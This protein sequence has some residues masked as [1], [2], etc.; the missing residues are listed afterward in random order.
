MAFQFLNLAPRRDPIQEGI[1][2]GLKGLTTGLV[3][4]PQDTL[5]LLSMI[6]KRNQS[7]K[8]SEKEEKAQLALESLVDRAPLSESQKMMFKNADKEGRRL[9]IQAWSQEP[10]FIEQL[11]EGKKHPLSPGGTSSLGQLSAEDIPLIEKKLIEQ[12]VDPQSAQQFIQ[13]AQQTN[14]EEPTN[15]LR[16]LLSSGTELATNL[17]LAT[18]ARSYPVAALGTGIEAGLGGINYISE[19]LG[20]DKRV[21]SYE[22]LQNMDF[23]PSAEQ[24]EK[25]YAHYP[26]EIQKYLKEKGSINP[27]KAIPTFG[28]VTEGLKEIG[29]S[30]GLP[31]KPKNSTERAMNHVAAIAGNITKLAQGGSPIETVKS[32]GKSLAAAFGAHTAGKLLGKATGNEKLAPIGEIGSLLLYSAFPGTLSGLSDKLYNKVNKVAGEA[33]KSGKKISNTSYRDKFVDLE[34]NLSEL[35]PLT[36]KKGTIPAGDAYELAT[37]AYNRSRNKLFPTAV[38]EVSPQEISN[39]LSLLRD[40]YKKIPKAGKPYI[41][42]L[43]ELERDMLG[44]GLDK[45]SP[46]TAQDLNNATSLFRSNAQFFNAYKDIKGMASRFGLPGAVAWYTVGLKPYFAGLAGYSGIKYAKA[47]VENPH[48]Q[49]LMTQL[50]KESAIGNT[51]AAGKIITRL[52]KESN[53]ILEKIPEKDRKAILD[54]AKQQGMIK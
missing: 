52:D 12:G 18:L 3:Q 40:T 53:K 50:A 28:Q 23:G 39:D 45:F 38:S 24:K 1:T 26:E 34:G 31:L 16:A 2:S 43:I 25:M 10:G 30:L 19:L 8:K 22:Q 15:P 46:G 4:S 6:E 51:T 37:N 44:K 14:A 29:S 32:L 36:N 54:Y 13:N 9:M 5:R 49:D 35:E 33:T 11:F 42:K 48:V 17:G 27:L 20:S 41:Q 7:L 21:P 47:L